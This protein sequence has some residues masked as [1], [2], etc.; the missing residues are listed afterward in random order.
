[1]TLEE[2]KAHFESRNGIACDNDEDRNEVIKL[3]LELGYGHGDSGVSRK[4]LQ[5]QYRGRWLAPM[6][7]GIGIE[8]YEDGRIHDIPFSDIAH[9]VYS[10]G[11]I[12]QVDDLI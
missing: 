5:G 11:T 10:K 4:C 2:L 3:M 9:L 8:F 7:D 1:M 12:A 6:Y